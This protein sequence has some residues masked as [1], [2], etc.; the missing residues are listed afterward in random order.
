MVARISL[1]SFA[2]DP[3][4]EALR[5]IAIDEDEKVFVME[6]GDFLGDGCTRFTVGNW[7]FGRNFKDS[8]T[9]KLG[10]L[11]SLKGSAFDFINDRLRSLRVRPAKFFNKELP[12]VEALEKFA[13]AGKIEGHVVVTCAGN[14]CE[15]S[16]ARA[17]VEGDRESA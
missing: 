10:N 4:P 6:L 14:R 1:S 11:L 15:V 3:V 12:E 17:V 2:F 9:G 13:G 5:A 7:P 8:D 16:A